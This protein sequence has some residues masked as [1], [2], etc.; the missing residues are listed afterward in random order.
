MPEFEYII[1]DDR[2]TEYGKF[3][4]LQYALY[5]IETL[6]DKFYKEDNLTISIKI[7]EKKM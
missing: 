7:K 6:F 4:E 5:F 2:G 3:T 1:I